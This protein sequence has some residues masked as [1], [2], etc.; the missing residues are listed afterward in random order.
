MR[1][2]RQRYRLRRSW[3]PDRRHRLH[4]PAFARRIGCAFGGMILFT[5]IAASTV[6]VF[7]ANA[8]H[9]GLLIGITIVAVLAVA[10]TFARTLRAVASK[11]SEQVRLR[12][13][14]MADVAHEL[15]TPL[16]ILQGR[17]EGLL[18]GVYPRDDEHLGELLSETQHLSRLV[19]DVR[20]LAN[21]EA[22]ALELRKET[23]DLAELI[24]DVVKAIGVPVT[25]DVPHELPLHADAVRIRE[26]LL[27]LLTNATQHA[28]GGRIAVD[29]KARGSEIVM[30]VRD[31]G[32]GIPAE[33]LP[34]LFERFQKGRHSK[35]SGLGLAIAK[36]L[37]EAHD[38]QIEVESSEGAGTHVT[39]TLP[40]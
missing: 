4:G 25:L 13:Q 8:P 7:I 27:N 30:R 21:A 37:V 36:K 32:P 2:P 23:F 40:A 24:R 26:V 9:R 35:G 10:A 28:A 38:G 34:R 3:P 18:D 14:L 33:E 12:R 19:E 6:G 5:A 20:T 31:D 11:F 17:I 39:I 22:G 15:R 29:A 1:G 16:A